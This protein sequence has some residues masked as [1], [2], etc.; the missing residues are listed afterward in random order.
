MSGDPVDSGLPIGKANKMVDR[1]V[2][3]D[4]LLA[5]DLADLHGQ[6]DVV[7]P[8]GCLSSGGTGKTNK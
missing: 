6:Q 4:D 3:P 7:T 5:P 8:S 1:P 2:G